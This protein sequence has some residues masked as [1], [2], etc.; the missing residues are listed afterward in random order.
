MLLSGLYL[1][2]SEILTF[3]VSK[4]KLN[5]DYASR[6]KVYWVGLARMGTRNARPCKPNERERKDYQT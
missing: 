3:S 6:Q 5:G 2:A 4:G 1:L